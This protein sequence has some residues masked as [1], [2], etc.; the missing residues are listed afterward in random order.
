M[1]IEG[2]HGFHGALL[3]PMK[4]SDDQLL[5]NPKGQT[6]GN[7]N[8]VKDKSRE[9]AGGES[10]LKDGELVK[11]IQEVKTLR[12]SVKKLN[13][14][15]VDMKEKLEL[16]EDELTDLRDQ[17][18]HM[19]A[20]GEKH[21]EKVK[22]L[23]SENV[24]LMDIVKVHDSNKTSSHEDT[25][26]LE[27]KIVTLESKI[28]EQSEQIIQ[29]CSAKASIDDLMADKQ[30]LEDKLKQEENSHKEREENTLKELKE[31]S[32]KFEE[33]LAVRTLR[34]KTLQEKI[35]K[36]EESGEALKD[37]G[38]ALKQDR[39]MLE[40]KL[41]REE[42]EN[43]ELKENTKKNRRQVDQKGIGF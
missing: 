27:G 13:K 33:Q 43:K 6:N 15:N 17:F 36:L 11:K 16:N 35:E 41:K 12:E 21:E 14:E 30:I 42:N 1:N 9:T 8:S 23:N 25:K 32:K 28:K 19:E 31:N 22:V 39:R 2:L 24:R 38:E 18:I 29:T 4:M 34:T 37:S 7:P 5:D 10:D 20:E 26:S 40:E 3:D